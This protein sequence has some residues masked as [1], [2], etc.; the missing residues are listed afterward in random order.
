MDVVQIVEAVFQMISV[1]HCFD[2]EVHNS[3]VLGQSV[4][5]AGVNYCQNFFPAGYFIGFAE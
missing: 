5:F 3:S 4:H 2:K 1:F